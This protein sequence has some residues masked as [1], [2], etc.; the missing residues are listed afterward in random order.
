MP[1]RV[2]SWS[3]S[4]RS[5]SHCLLPCAGLAYRPPHPLGGSRT[6]RFSPPKAAAERTLEE[7]GNGLFQPFRSC[8]MALTPQRTATAK[9]KSKN[10]TNK[11]SLPITTKD[12][13]PL[14]ALTTSTAP[15]QAAHPQIYSCSCNHSPARAVKDGRKHKW[16]VPYRNYSV[17]SVWKH[18]PWTEA[19]DEDRASFQAV[20]PI[21]TRKV[22]VKT[23]ISR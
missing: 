6:S 3:I 19:N 1:G 16:K 12:S 21:L 14:Y 11:G 2:V 20:P 9:E 10:G 4:A 8:K 18:L 23:F 5:G 15:R 17:A 13:H 22:G 7:E